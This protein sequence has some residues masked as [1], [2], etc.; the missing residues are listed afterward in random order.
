MCLVDDQAVIFSRANLVP[1]DLVKQ[2]A[3]C[4]QTAAGADGVDA[5]TR[6][7][8]GL[9]EQCAFAA[10]LIVIPNHDGVCGFAG[11]HRTISEIEFSHIPSGR[12]KNDCEIRM[13]IETDGCEKAPRRMRFD[14]APEDTCFERMLNYLRPLS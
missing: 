5:V 1:V 8:T 14:A 13:D 6:V 10:L 2:N 7:D 11:A 9:D 4:L 12:C 3:V